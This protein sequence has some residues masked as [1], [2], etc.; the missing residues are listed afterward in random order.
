LER[1]Y[2]EQ[3][4]TQVIRKAAELQ[5]RLAPADAPRPGGIAEGE[6]VRI[7]GELGLEER[8]VKEAL[9]DKSTFASQDK[10]RDTSW[11]RTFERTAAGLPGSEA[12]EIALDEFGPT[13]GMSTSPTTVGDTLT[14]QSMAGLSHCEMLVSKKGGRTRVKV[15]TSTF[16]PFLAFGLPMGL[17]L[18]IVIVSLTEYSHVAGLPIAVADVLI[19]LLGLG[20][21]RSVVRRVNVWSNRKVSA[22]LDSLIDRINAEAERMPQ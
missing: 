21:I 12:F 18:F 15:G 5:D 8:F 7:A 20:L 9:A 17:A 10:G 13:S 11:D 22:K 16:L 1:H 6:L 4:V 2:T 14:Y 19:A 3:E